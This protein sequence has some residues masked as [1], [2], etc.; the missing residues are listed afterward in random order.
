MKAFRVRDIGQVEPGIA[1]LKMD[2][3]A[4]VL[5]GGTTRP[6]LTVSPALAHAHERNGTIVECDFRLDGV[7]GM[8]L[9]P[10]GVAEDSAAFDEKAIVVVPAGGFDFHAQP[11]VHLP[12]V[13]RQQNVARVVVLAKGERIEAFPVVRTLAESGSARKVVLCFDGE[14][15][16]FS[17]S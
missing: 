16:T 8:E 1:W 5:V 2:G 12:L 14:R 3:T 7:G 10:A 4:Y 15:V 6:Y 9:I 13:P 17:P 11:G